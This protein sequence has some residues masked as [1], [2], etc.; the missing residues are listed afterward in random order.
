MIPLWTSLRFQNIIR[1]TNR[2]LETLHDL[3]IV[4]LT[5][6]L[7]IVIIVGLGILASPNADLEIDSKGLELTWTIFPIIILVRLAFPRIYLLCFQDR[8]KRNVEYTIKITSRQWSWASEYLEELVDHLLD[9]ELLENVSSIE[10]P[11]LIPTGV[12]RMLLRRTDVLHSLGIP[13]LGIKLD[14]VPGRLNFTTLETKNIALHWAS[15]YELCG[16]GHRAI[17]LTFLVLK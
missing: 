14:S 6:I 8:I 12:I 3:I 7:I 9:F 4:W 16:R 13:R 10:N 2:F 5:V 17:P 11:T 15:C 1:R